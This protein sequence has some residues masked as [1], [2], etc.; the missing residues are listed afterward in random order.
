MTIYM[1]TLSTYEVDLP[2]F[3]AEVTGSF[4]TDQKLAYA[5][6]GQ[7]KKVDSLTL[8]INNM[9]KELIIKINSNPIICLCLFAGSY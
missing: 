9:R 5:M 1:I 3:F 6:F 8:K 2:Y 4:H 7:G